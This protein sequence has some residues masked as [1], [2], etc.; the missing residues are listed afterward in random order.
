[1]QVWNA[2]RP[3]ISFFY[4]GWSLVKWNSP[5]PLGNNH[6]QSFSVH[7]LFFFFLS[8]SK[9]VWRHCGRYIKLLPKASTLLVISLYWLKTNTQCDFLWPSAS[10][11]SNSCV[12][13]NIA[14]IVVWKSREANSIQFESLCVKQNVKVTSILPIK[15]ANTSMKSRYWPVCWCISIGITA[16]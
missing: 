13:I 12:S 14:V 5:T 10:R 6:S 11:Y 2:S 9:L 1:M 4:C 3:L 7:N 8:F 16:K 15:D